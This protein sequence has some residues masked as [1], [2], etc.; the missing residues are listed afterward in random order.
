MIIINIIIYA[1]AWAEKEHV[2]RPEEHLARD[3][4]AAQSLDQGR[5]GRLGRNKLSLAVQRLYSIV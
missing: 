1:G 4:F 5:L 2:Q 3:V